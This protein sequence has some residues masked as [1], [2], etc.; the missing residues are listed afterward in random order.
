[1]NI[2]TVYIIVSYK[3]EQQTVSYVERLFAQKSTLYKIIIVNNGASDNSSNELCKSLNAIRIDDIN[4][5]KTKDSVVYVIDSPNNLGFA[6]ANNM[7]AVFARHMFDPKYLVFT[8]TDVYLMQDCVVDSMILKIKE[9]PEVGIVGPKVIG[10]DGNLQSPEPYL[11]F[12]TRYVSKPLTSRFWSEAKR[13][14]KLK[15]K[16]T[17]NA[18]EGYVDK[19]MGSFF[20]VDAEAF[21]NCGMMDPNTFL[22]YEELILSE[23]MKAIGKYTYY[24]PE[25]TIIHEHGVTIKKYNSR[26]K[27]EKLNFESAKYYYHTYKHTSLLEIYLGKLLYFLFWHLIILK[28]KLK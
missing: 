26:L 7:G 4:V 5:E 20:L 10:L 25:V 15:E 24:Y 13:R 17:E 3:N 27:M 23:R 21:F 19:V 22:Y 2:N 18:K 8:N 9:H 6:R 1:M 28:D 12:W 16:Y 14:I 11:S